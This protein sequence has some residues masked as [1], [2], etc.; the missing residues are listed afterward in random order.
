MEHRQ[1]E[2]VFIHII[3][4]VMQGHLR[5]TL[6][7]L[8]GHRNSSSKGAVILLGG[9]WTSE[10]EEERSISL[11]IRHRW[12]IMAERNPRGDCQYFYPYSTIL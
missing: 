3:W 6:Q 1:N 12:P 8:L 10:F 4:E 7:E 5:V 9:N 11:A 2:A